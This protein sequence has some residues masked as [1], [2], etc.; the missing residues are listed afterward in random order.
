MTSDFEPIFLRLAGTY[1]ACL[2]RVMGNDIE[3]CPIPDEFEG[4]LQGMRDSAI[5]MKVLCHEQKGGKVRF[6]PFLHQWVME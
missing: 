1:L 4:S 5:A 3:G 6:D 2:W